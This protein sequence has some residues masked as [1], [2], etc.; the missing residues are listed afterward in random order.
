MFL[1]TIIFADDKNK[2]GLIV[3][4]SKKKGQELMDDSRFVSCNVTATK[5]ILESII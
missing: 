5:N 3:Y 2:M 4:T 1:L